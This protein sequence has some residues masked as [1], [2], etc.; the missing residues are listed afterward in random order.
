MVI[1]HDFEGREIRL[2]TDLI[3]VRSEQIAQ[4]YKARW[5]IEVFL[6]LDQVKFEFA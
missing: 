3:K 6:P 2:A 4:M 1:F 5:Q